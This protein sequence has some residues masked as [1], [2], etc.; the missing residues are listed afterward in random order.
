MIQAL[1]DDLEE[2]R[3]ECGSPELGWVFPNLRRL[4]W[5]AWKRSE[6]DRATK[7]TGR[8]L[9]RP[10]YLCHTFASLLIEEGRT[11]EEVMQQTGLTR[12]EVIAEYGHIFEN[13]AVRTPV[14]ADTRIRDARASLGGERVSGTRVPR[15]GVARQLPPAPAQS[16]ERS[17]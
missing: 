1:A 12:E 5:Q 7:H 6:Y 13:A 15:S 9:Q 10:Y 3:V 14:P 8:G 4:N 16:P 2:W 11:L 17:A